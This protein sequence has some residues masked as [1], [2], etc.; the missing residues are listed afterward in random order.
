MVILVQGRAKVRTAAVVQEKPYIV[1]EAEVIPE[2]RQL[3][4]GNRPLVAAVTRRI[5]RW[6]EAHVPAEDDRAYIR[7]RMGDPAMLCELAATLALKDAS[8]K[9]LLLETDDV[10]VRLAMLRALFGADGRPIGPADAIA[11]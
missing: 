2:E 1:C 11:N 5:S 8:L 10:N 3:A 4:A 6:V 7:E 9:Q